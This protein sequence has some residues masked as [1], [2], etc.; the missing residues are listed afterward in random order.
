LP[1]ASKPN[2]DIDSLSSDLSDILGVAMKPSRL[3]AGR[4]RGGAREQEEKLEQ[5][6]KLQEERE[7]EQRREEQ[8]QE[9]VREEEG[10]RLHLQRAQVCVR[11]CVHM[12]R[13]AHVRVRFCL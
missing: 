13:C 10:A 7:E 12:C 9:R 5:E 1:S 4:R 8:E 2:A 3:G 6:K 11:A